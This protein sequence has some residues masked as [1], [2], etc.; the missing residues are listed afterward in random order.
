VT[1]VFQN[2]N[3]H[4]AK[5]KSGPGHHRLWIALKANQKLFPPV[6][7]YLSGVWLVANAYVL[8]VVL[9]VNTSGGPW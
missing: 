4:C 9:D 5:A 1:E 3:A 2:E 6:G 8:S 7:M